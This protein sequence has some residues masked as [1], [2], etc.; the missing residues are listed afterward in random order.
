MVLK[1][2]AVAGGGEPESELMSIPDYTGPVPRVGEYIY[3]RAGPNVMSVKTVT[4]AFAN[5]DWS[6]A[7]EPV[8]EVHV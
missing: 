3:H 6:Y 7:G 4:Y 5:P 2:I 8:L 1:I